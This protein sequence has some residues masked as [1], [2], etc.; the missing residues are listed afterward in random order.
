MFNKPD[1]FA[2]LIFTVTLHSKMLISMK[3][4]HKLN[5]Q[6]FWESVRLMWVHTIIGLVKKKKARLAIPLKVIYILK[7]ISVYVL[8]VHG[9]IS[10]SKI[11]DGIVLLYHS[12][13][14]YY[15]TTIIPVLN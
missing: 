11:L 9:S 1:I 15:F 8:V 4:V 14:N 3:Y 10:S 12:S 2:I 13:E 6:T 7:K 5:V